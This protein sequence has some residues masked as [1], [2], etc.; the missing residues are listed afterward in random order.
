MPRYMP[1]QRAIAMHLSYMP[2]MGSIQVYSSFSAAIRDARAATGRDP[3]TGSMIDPL[4]QGNWL[5]AIGYMTLLDQIG[6]CFKPRS[7]EVVT[8]NSFTKALSYFAD[9][10]H[11]ERQALYA[12]R[13]S[14]VH[15]FALYNIHPKNS[16]LTHHFEVHA[17]PNAPLI[18]LPTVQWDGRR[19]ARTPD[20]TTRVNLT[21]VCTLVELVASKLFELA[22]ADELEVVLPGGSDELLERYGMYRRPTQS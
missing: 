9:L 13:C 11:A 20:S 22:N 15:D 18:Q 2:A 3:D 12:L 16:S 1:E 4:R 7:A 5:G 21:A 17:D 6:T 8:G 10:N 19:S 14:F